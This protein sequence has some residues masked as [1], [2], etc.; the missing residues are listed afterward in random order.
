MCRRIQYRCAEMSGSFRFLSCFSQALSTTATGIPVQKAIATPFSSFTVARC[1]LRYGATRH[2]TVVGRH[3][4][5]RWREDSPACHGAGLTVRLMKG[6]QRVLHSLAQGLPYTWSQPPSNTPLPPPPL[7][8]T[9]PK[10]LVS[11]S[12][13]QTHTAKRGEGLVC[14]SCQTK[15]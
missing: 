2:D 10:P 3:C 11:K 8:H 4:C 14:P 13:W 15:G 1:T 12:I 5:D 7:G 9:L 6:R